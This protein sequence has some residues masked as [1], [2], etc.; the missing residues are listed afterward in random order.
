MPAHAAVSACW[1]LLTT[2]DSLAPHTAAAV[3]FCARSCEAYG[4]LFNHW[5]GWHRASCC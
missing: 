3:H 4:R 2:A 1:L 5:A